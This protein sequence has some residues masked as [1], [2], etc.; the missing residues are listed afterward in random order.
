[1]LKIILISLLSFSVAQAGEIAD[2]TG[3]GKPRTQPQPPNP[4]NAATKN[5][6]P[7]ILQELHKSQ[8]ELQKSEGASCPEGNF[9]VHASG[10]DT[11]VT[12]FDRKEDGFYF[13]NGIVFSVSPSSRR[14]Y[15]DMVK[16]QTGT[17]ACHNVVTI[18]TQMRDKVNIKS[19]ETLERTCNGI[20]TTTRKT[21]EINKIRGGKL[22]VLYKSETLNDKGTSWSTDQLCLYKPPRQF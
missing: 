15:S 1:M 2:G 21:F 4:K 22:N 8:L 14:E 13:G 11:Q 7:Q 17:L 12:I 16:T 18:E 3:G 9:D 20:K 6:I 19:I 5:K 10:N